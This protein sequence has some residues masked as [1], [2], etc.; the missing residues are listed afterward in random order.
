[1]QI[2]C[3]YDTDLTYT[4]YTKL[5]VFV[6]FLDLILL[7]TGQ[8]YIHVGKQPV[9]GYMFYYLFS[10]LILKERNCNTSSPSPV[11]ITEKEVNRSAIL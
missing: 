7:L 8:R 3:L 9:F 5:S 4:A 11:H 10:Y 1:M 2:Q 6:P